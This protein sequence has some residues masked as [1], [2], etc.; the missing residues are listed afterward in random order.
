MVKPKTKSKEERK[1]K[2]EKQNYMCSVGVKRN[3][4]R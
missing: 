3:M 4:A 2:K 1:L